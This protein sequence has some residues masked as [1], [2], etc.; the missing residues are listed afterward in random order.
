MGGMC[1]R[2]IMRDSRVG[3]EREAEERLKEKCWERPDV[4]VIRQV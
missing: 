2:E 4:Y 3:S 1:T